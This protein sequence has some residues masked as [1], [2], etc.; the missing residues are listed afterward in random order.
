MKELG[1]VHVG[2]PLKSLSRVN[3]TIRG[4]H[5]GSL[6]EVD[7]THNVAY[8]NVLSKDIITIK[9]LHN[10]YESGLYVCDRSS[11][12]VF[13]GQQIVGFSEASALTG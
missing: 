8:E 9:Q 1:V 10:V 5:A 6:W 13:G 3:R 11:L 2:V 4:S 12:R 7:I